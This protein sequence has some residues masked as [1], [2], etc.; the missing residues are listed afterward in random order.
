[1]FD[2]HASRFQDQGALGH[3]YFASEE[4]E[5]LLV[6]VFER[7]GLNV[8]GFVSIRF[9]GESTLSRNSGEREEQCDELDFHKGA[10]LA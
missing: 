9:F 3:E 10:N 6:V 1:L 2:F 4:G 5:L 7:I 8:H